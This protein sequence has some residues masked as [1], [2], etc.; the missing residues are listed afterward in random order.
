[1]TAIVAVLNKHAVAI[2]ADSAVTMGDTHKVV[3]SANKIFTLS[4]YHPVAV[5]TYNNAAFMG[6]PWDIII[7]E[8]RRK[9]KDKSFNTIKEY[10][11]DFLQ[12][13]R[14]R[15]F[16]CEKETQ[17][18]C[19]R[20]E[21]VAFVDMCLNNISRQKEIKKENVAEEDLRKFLWDCKENLSK[22]EKCPEFESYSYDKFRSQ[23]YMIV[24][25]FS[26][27]NNLSLSDDLCETFFYYLSAQFNLRMYTG[28]VFVGY[29]EKE[30]YPSL[31]QMNMALAI[32]GHL[33]YYYEK[34]V[35]ISDN[36]AAH[37]SPFAQTDVTDTILR[38]I[39]PAFQQIINDNV[40]NYLSSF[41][42]GIANI[43]DQD[44]ATSEV[45]SVIRQKFNIKESTEALVKRINDAMFQSYTKPLIDTVISLDKED[46]ANMAE[47]FIFLTSL[48]RRMQ[49]R[50]ETVGGPV[51]VAV[52]SKGDGFVWINR[53][54]YF[55]PE[56]NAAF[57]QNYLRK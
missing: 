48:V 32:S 5:M 34:E 3:N 23:F 4:K 16:F 25:D 40:G 21:L 18:A 27:E 30:I 8:Y 13:I 35:N 46:M 41:S 20:I 55:K 6:V 36:L 51:D 26:K 22:W 17:L 54:H 14:K 12:F 49:P 28:L 44:K 52:I 29:G 31:H 24:E 7:K 38:G 57:F 53:K 10:A 11:E 33:R 15:N 50:E 2:A 45:A 42:E 19:L 43:L 39:N 47:S 9:L 56:L 37:I 1:M